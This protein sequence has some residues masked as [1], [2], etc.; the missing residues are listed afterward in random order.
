MTL[1]VNRPDLTVGVIGTGAMG[2][3]IVRD[4]VAGSR[5]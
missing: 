2:L 3:G 4:A 1:D 5:A